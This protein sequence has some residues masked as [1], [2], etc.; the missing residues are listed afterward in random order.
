VIPVVVSHLDRRETKSATLHRLSLETLPLCIPIVKRALQIQCRSSWGSILSGGYAKFTLTLARH[1]LEATPMPSSDAEF[2]DQVS[3]WVRTLVLSLLRLHDDVAKGGGAARTAVEYATSTIIHGMG[4]ESFLGVVD[5][6][7]EDGDGGG[8]VTKKKSLS[9]SSTTTGGGIR[10][11]RAWLLPL[12]K[13]SA[14]GTGSRNAAADDITSRT[15]L[16]FFQGNVLNLARK[17]D[18]ASADGHRTAAESSIQKA[19]VVELWS[20]F[21]MFCVYPLDVKENFGSV[22]KIVVKALGDHGRYPK[23]VVSAM[24]FVFL[25]CVRT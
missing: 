10:E 22:A 15:H 4:V 17:C 11:D 19:R 25:L 12:M 3:S 13:Q 2:R 9:S 18:A 1:L 6:V 21:P 7:D 20:L 24:R 5:F 23:L 8:V 14:A 16:S